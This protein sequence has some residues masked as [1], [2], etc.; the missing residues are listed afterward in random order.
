MKLS[1]VLVVYNMGRAAPR[2]I[3]SLC[4]TY[5]RDIRAEDYEI[6]VVENGSTEPLDEAGIRALGSNVRYFYLP[7]APPSPAY[8]INFG[9]ARSSGEVL[10]IM[11]DGAHMLTPGVLGFAL[12]AFAAMDNPVVVTL[13]FFLGPGPQMETVQQGYDE[14]AEDA[15]LEQIDWPA[16]GYRLFEIGVPF[17]IEPG[18]VRP[19]LLWM[20]RQFESNCLFMRRTSFDAV[21]GCEARFDIPGGGILIPDLYRQLSRLEGAKLVQ[22]IGEASFHQL[23]G[24]TTTNVTREEQKAKWQ[25]YLEQY[26]LVRGEPYHVSDKPLHFFGHIPH[27][28]VR[29]LLIT[30]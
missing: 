30:G 6:I 19:K 13:P 3:Q 16:E 2:T 10:A 22:L 25:T 26:E 23:H 12:Q 20:V 29:Q 17:R 1:V 8:A 27:P 18:G 14:A 5:Q 15:L 24:G 11:V 9:V 28:E 4:A 7:D 21:G